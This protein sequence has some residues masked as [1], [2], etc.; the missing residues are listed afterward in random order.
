ITMLSGSARFGVPPAS[1]FPNGSRGLL[2]GGAQGEPWHSTVQ[3]G[4]PH[5]PSETYDASA[6]AG[7]WDRH[8]FAAQAMSAPW[9]GHSL[10]RPGGVMDWPR[11]QD[12]S[13]L[14]SLDSVSGPPT[15]RSVSPMRQQARTPSPQPRQQLPLGR[16]QEACHGLD[17]EKRH[18]FDEL[19][20]RTAEADSLAREAES[21][22][23][24]IREEQERR[25]SRTADLSEQ[26]SGLERENK[27]LQMRLG[28]V[29]V[30]DSSKLSNGTVLKRE[31]V[32][33]TMELE[34]LMREFQQIHQDKLF[35]GVSAIANDMLAL[36]GSGGSGDFRMVPA[37]SVSS[38]NAVA[39]PAAAFSAACGARQFPGPADGA[40]LPPSP[41]PSVAPIDP[42]TQ[43]A[44][45][46]RLQ[47][48]GDVVVFSSDKFDACSASGRGIPPGALR[49][50]PRRCDHV[51]LVEVLMPYWAEGLCPVCRC[52]FAYSRACDAGF[53]DCDRYSS[54]STSV[55]QSAKANAH[56][57]RLGAHRL[58]QHPSGSD[59]GSAVV[60]SSGAGAASLR[61]PKTLRAMVSEQNARSPSMSMASGGGCWSNSGTRS[62]ASALEASPGG[63]NGRGARS[64]SQ[65][66]A[67]AV[68]VSHSGTSSAQRGRPL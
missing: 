16:M 5:W 42:E 45:K 24:Q 22:R 41:C 68:S 10:R 53:D 62:V 67:E 32:A 66:S 23:E 27:Q 51:F 43:Q 46:R 61:G 8:G 64:P 34:K 26:L 4:T 2:G 48:L 25:R 47:S 13:P 40:S 17:Q 29:Q 44:L 38:R 54:V 15:I 65:K 59:D 20:S 14:R 7:Q 6:A 58:A 11:W 21:L 19:R 35:L 30:Q 9:S 60:S 56:A 28:Q 55:S 57:S 50:R 37:P 63:R 1:P 33:K 39:P 49:V 36:C 3:L 52:S 12:A 31:V 18:I